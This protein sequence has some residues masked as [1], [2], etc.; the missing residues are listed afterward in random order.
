MAVIEHRGKNFRSVIVFWLAW[1]TV[2][3]WFSLLP[4]N[5]RILPILRAVEP[6]LGRLPQSFPG[7]RIEK[8][9]LG[10]VPAE[11]IVPEAD[12][13]RHARG[14]LVY[15]HGGAF[16]CCN[17][18]THRRIAALL[19]RD[20]GVPVYNVGYRQY[21][22]GGVGTSVADGFAAYRALVD[23]GEFDRIVL[24]GD[25]AGGFV[26]GKVSEYAAEAGIQRPAAFAGFSPFLDIS[27][28]LPRSSRHDA[29]LPM[30]QV[31]KLVPKYRRGPEPLRGPENLT[32]DAT[33]AC[34]PPS[35]LFVATDEALMID[36]LQLHD[37][38]QRA[39]VPAEVHVYDGQIHA[40]VVAAG[41][42]PE[43]SHAYELTVSF[44]SG[45]LADAEQAPGLVQ[46]DTEPA[47]PDALTREK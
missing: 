7:V 31:R 34:F 16:I 5:D 14:A 43:A 36:S 1:I 30:R 8:I 39:G 13:P 33:A 12:I 23:S 6:Y 32:T 42:T 2:K 3:T 44:L 28:T 46:V 20:V 37:S 29:V 35:L 21:P 41:L 38:L 11:R 40:F 17:L 10:G 4:T 25:S 9:T 47:T 45:R 19:A 26:C 24:V 15:Y 27:D 18:D 22:D